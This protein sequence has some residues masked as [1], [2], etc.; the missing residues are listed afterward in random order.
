MVFVMG[1]VMKLL[2]PGLRLSVKSM[3]VRLLS[4]SATTSNST[5]TSTRLSSSPALTL[6]DFIQQ[7]RK[8]EGKEGKEGVEGV[9]EDASV[10]DSGIDDSPHYNA[11]Y[12]LQEE[13]LRFHI[14][15][16]GCQM[17]VSDSEIVRSILISHGH[18]SVS[19]IH[20]ADV[21]LT[22]TCAIRENAE[23]KVWHR[24][25]YLHS[26]RRKNKIKQKKSY[27][28]IVGVL[29]CMAE[30]L[31]EKMLEEDSVDFV[32]GPDA[33]RD[34]PRLISNVVNSTG[35]KEANTLLSLEETYAD[36]SPVREVNS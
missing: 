14:E 16:Y 31:K 8:K 17:N 4:S 22:N 21:I 20:S 11:K 36:I 30:R 34:I 1:S 32:C 6:K 10:I 5:R 19:D 23:S 13:G 27:Y 29:G 28:P 2:R 25:N 9:V 7:S 12:M 3:S 18:E 15:T 33:Y 35:Q 26:V 24:L